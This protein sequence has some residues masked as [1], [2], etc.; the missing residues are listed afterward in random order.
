MAKGLGSVTEMIVQGIFPWCFTPELYAAKPE[1]MEQ[2]ASF[3]R[4]RPAQPLPAFLQQSEAVIAHDAAAQLAKIKAPTQI[5]F[6]RYDLVT[7]ARFA[8]TLKSGIAKSE[9]IVFEDCSHAPIYENVAEFN[10][11]TLAFLSRQ[12]G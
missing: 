3:V 7:G 11:K 6:G 1:H 8:D 10:A 2:L 5:T 12:A 4:S 9:L